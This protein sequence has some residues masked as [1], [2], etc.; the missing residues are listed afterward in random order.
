MSRWKLTT[1]FS[2]LMGDG[3]MPSAV[4]DELVDQGVPVIVEMYPE[5]GRNNK[6]AEKDRRIAQLEAAIR[7]Y[8]AHVERCEGTDFLSDVYADESDEPH[9]SVIRLFRVEQY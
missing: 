8:I 3:P 7:W 4:V 5:R 2:E 6:E 1:P 9:R